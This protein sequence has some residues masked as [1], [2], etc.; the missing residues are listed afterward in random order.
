MVPLEIPDTLVEEKEVVFD[1]IDTLENSFFQE[2]YPSQIQVGK[3]AARSNVESRVQKSV[4][5]INFML[6]SRY[7]FLSFMLSLISNE[8]SPFIFLFMS[9]SR[10]HRKVK[11]I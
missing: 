1:L 7:T 9:K 5:M 8:W 3:N 10:P 6:T 4:L 11:P 2:P